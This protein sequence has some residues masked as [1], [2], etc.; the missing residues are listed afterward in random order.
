MDHR[1]FDA[2]FVQAFLYDPEVYFNMKEATKCFYVSVS[3]LLLVKTDIMRDYLKQHPLS[4]GN[5]NELFSWVYNFFCFVNKKTP[6]D[7]EYKT[8]YSNFSEQPKSK[9]FWSHPYWA[10]IHYLAYINSNAWNSTSL[11]AYKAFISCFQYIIVCSICR[12]H[13]AKNLEKHH[14]D[15]YMKNGKIFEWSVNLH[16]T[17]NLFTGKPIFSLKEAIAQQR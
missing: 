4:L 11:N 7:Q 13:L 3:E 8:V 16:N 15:D 14:L 6:S 2:L 17:V 12:T 10:L 1:I 5:K 9:V